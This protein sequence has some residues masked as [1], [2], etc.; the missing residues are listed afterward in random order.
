[1][2]TTVTLDPDLA[3]RLRELARQRQISFKAAINTAV[4]AGLAT[5]MEQKHPYREKVRDL[6]VQPGVDLTK[7]LQLAAT[8]EDE[9]TIQK[10]AL[11][12]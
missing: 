9:A 6:G 12:K 11:R 4:R 5:E 3:A 2:R 1:M 7:A 10:L 8:L